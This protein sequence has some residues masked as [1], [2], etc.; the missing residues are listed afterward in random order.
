MWVKPNERDR[1]IQEAVSGEG[2]DGHGLLEKQDAARLL[3]PTHRLHQEPRVQ[4][5]GGQGRQQVGEVVA[6]D[7]A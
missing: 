3:P 2:D 6:R 5:L 7:P 1:A 4:R